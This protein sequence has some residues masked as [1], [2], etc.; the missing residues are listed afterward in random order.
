MAKGERVEI[1]RYAL[2][3]DGLETYRVPGIRVTEASLTAFDRGRSV[4]RLRTRS[5]FHEVEGQPTTD[6][7]LRSTWRDDLYVVLVGVA[8]DGRATFRVLVNPLVMWIWVGGVV[9]ALGAIIALVPI[10]S[11]QERPFAVPLEPSMSPA[12]SMLERPI[13]GGER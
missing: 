5:L 8:P 11:R 10:R 9:V 13:E 6:I 12:P 7:G 1:G 2:R 3:Y 4:G